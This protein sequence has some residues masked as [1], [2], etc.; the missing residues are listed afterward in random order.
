MNKLDRYFEQKQILIDVIND[1]GPFPTSWNRKIEIA[2]IHDSNKPFIA[3]Y[4][5]ELCMPAIEY[6]IKVLRGE[7]AE[8]VRK[9]ITLAEKD[10][11]QAKDEARKE[12]KEILNEEV[13]CEE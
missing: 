9:A 5:H 12:L 2:I 8:I 10:L 7:K 6:L 13:R 3:I 1:F 11:E 4:P